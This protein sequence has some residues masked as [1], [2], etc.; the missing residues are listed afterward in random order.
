MKSLVVVVVFA[1]GLSGHVYSQDEKI[2][3][4]KATKPIEL[5]EV[6]IKSAGKDF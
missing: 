5:P 2:G 4:D 6:V 1:L 3:N